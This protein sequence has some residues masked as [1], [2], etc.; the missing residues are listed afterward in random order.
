MCSPNP[1]LAQLAVHCCDFPVHRKVKIFR[2]RSCARLK[3]EVESFIVIQRHR[4]PLVN[5][6]F[7]A[8]HFDLL[9][10]C[11]ASIPLSGPVAAAEH[12]LK[13]S[14]VCP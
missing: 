13:S 9:L 10:L 6:F 11:V 5:F 8:V 3:R 4:R 2:I 7:F 12:R 14:K 1:R